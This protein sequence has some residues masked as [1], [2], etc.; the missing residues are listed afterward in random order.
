[1]LRRAGMRVFPIGF[2]LAILLSIRE[3]NPYPYLCVRFGAATA[4]QSFRTA[5]CL[6]KRAIRS[7]LSILE[8]AGSDLR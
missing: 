1:M 2:V 6:R 3:I 7:Y 5:R 8:S 4:E